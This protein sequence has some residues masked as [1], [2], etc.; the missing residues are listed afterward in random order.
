MTRA[1]QPAIYDVTYRATVA[2][3][4]QAEV[5][6]RAAFAAAT[7]ADAWER[8]TAIHRG[9]DPTSIEIELRQSPVS[10]GHSPA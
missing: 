2:G 6:L 7:L 8:L 4:E 5:R 9:V 10:T 3:G 1:V